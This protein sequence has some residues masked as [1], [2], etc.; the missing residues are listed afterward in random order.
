MLEALRLIPFL[1][2]VPTEDLAP[3][4]ARARRVTC[5]A[6]EVLFRRGDPAEAFFIVISGHII[7]YLDGDDD[8]SH[9]ARI[10]GPR[11]S[12]G[13]WCVCSQ[14]ACPVTAHAFGPAELI[15][16]PG[17]ALAA[18]FAASPDLACALIGETTVRLRGLVRQMM[19]LKM[20]TAAQRVGG[21]LLELTHG[22]EEP[23]EIRLPFEKKLL[24]HDL[25][26]QPETL[27]RI[28]LK[29]QGIGVHYHR[30]IDAFRIA[31]VAAL[32]QFCD[33]AGPHP[34]PLADH[35]AEC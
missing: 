24:A 33:E 15:M 8:P 12:F 17:D 6:R 11:E 4:A 26:M 32:R 25:G 16:I 29:L 22:R 5:V 2:Q 7:L 20:K 35:A 10:C 31:D 21:Y 9:I 27:S 13:E 3:L 1:A 23:C 19:D 28:L 34:T 18:L 30:S 14:E